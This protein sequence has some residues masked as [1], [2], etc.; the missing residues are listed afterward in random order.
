M[1]RIVRLQP[2][3]PTAVRPPD[4]E[5][6]DRA[7]HRPV[8][9]SFRK[10]KDVDEAADAQA[11]VHEDPDR[12]GPGNLHYGALDDLP[13][14]QPFPNPSP[15]GVCHHER[16]FAPPP[17]PTARS[18]PTGTGRIGRQGRADRAGPPLGGC[19]LWS[20]QTLL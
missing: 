2:D 19:V 4:L 1:A 16:I 7:F 10:Q 3:L 17:A 8:I 11:D 20:G 9:A 6:G 18:G 13:E 14:A 12:T 15:L 5:V